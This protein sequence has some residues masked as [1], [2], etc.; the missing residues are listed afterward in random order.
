MEVQVSLSNHSVSARNESS[1][2]TESE[3]EKDGDVI[4][5]LLH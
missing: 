1:K 5:A 3:G 2:K 4:F